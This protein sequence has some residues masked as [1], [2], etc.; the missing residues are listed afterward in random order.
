VRLPLD[1]LLSEAELEDARLPGLE[2]AGEDAVL[3]PPAERTND[4]DAEYLLAL[5]NQTCQFREPAAP[6]RA[7]GPQRELDEVA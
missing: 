4:L 7:A 5:G 2:T 1:R 6:V 3:R